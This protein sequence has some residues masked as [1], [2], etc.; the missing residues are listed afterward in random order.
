LVFPLHQLSALA[1]QPQPEDVTADIRW[2]ERS[3]AIIMAPLADYP[4]QRE[5]AD[6][7]ET[8]PAVAAGGPRRAGKTE[9]IGRKLLAKCL[10]EDGFTVVIGTS[11]LAGPTKNWLDRKGRPSA[12]GIL[13]E[14]GFLP[15]KT[16]RSSWQSEWCQVTRSMGHIV[17]IA[18][19]WGS[20]I[21]VIDVGQ[22]HLIDKHRGQTAH[23]WWFDEAQSI[24]PLPTVLK[25]L[26]N[27]TKLDHGGCIVLSGTPGEEIDSLFGQIST[28]KTSGYHR[29]HLSS[30]QN[31]RYGATFEERWA[32]VIATL[33]KPDAGTYQISDDDV[34]RLAL[35]SEP[36]IEAIRHGS[37]DSETGKW[38]ATLS[39]SFLREI[40]GRWVGD[41][42]SLV[43]H[44]VPEIYWID[45]EPEME[46]VVELLPAVSGKWKAAIGHDVGWSKG[47]MAW[48]VTLC[49]D[50][51]STAYTVFSYV[52]KRMPE[53]EEFA[54]TEHL[55]DR[56]RTAGIDV[57]GVVAD[58]TGMLS[59]THASWDRTLRA[60]INIPVI[61]PNKAATLQRLKSVNLDLARGHLKVAAGGPLDVEGR[62][63]RWHPAK[64]G[65]I[66]VGR[67][68]TI[69][70][71]PMLPGDHCLDSL[72]YALQLL[73]AHWQRPLPEDNRP[74]LLRQLENAFGA[75][76]LA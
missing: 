69:G 74:V 60:R 30:W 55:I 70:N 15:P 63:L 75:D 44:W 35:C 49:A 38:V 42:G 9:A 33:I 40:M 71:K 25:D 72:R 37:E 56:I 31:P 32:Y 50:H 46:Q 66:D 62:H 21:S 8:D 57:L 7:L 51:H 54:F 16:A 43:Y 29:V 52:A 19:A 4:A 1:K 47:S 2:R 64:A 58:M 17:S 23:V 39:A 68:V 20:Q 65:V 12:V 22:M 36:E 28:G 53:H 26:A 18:F 76:K 67:S 34:A 13:R 5:L 61:L 45:H 3:A 59:A 6:L 11:T 48:T 73:T 10:L 14:L 27:P 24:M 41:Y